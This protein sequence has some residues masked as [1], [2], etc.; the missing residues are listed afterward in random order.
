MVMTMTTGVVPPPCMVNPNL[1][2]E[3]QAQEI[4]ECN[5]AEAQQHRILDQAVVRRRM[6]VEI[7]ILSVGEKRKWSGGDDD[8]DKDKGEDDDIDLDIM[9]TKVHIGLC[10]FFGLG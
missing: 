10:W 9:V 2:P 3:A 6:V 5:I 1:A 7:P 8:K 4:W